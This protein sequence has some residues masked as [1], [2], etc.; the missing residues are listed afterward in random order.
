MFNMPSRSAQNVEYFVNSDESSFTT[1]SRLPVLLRPCTKPSKA[2]IKS[3]ESHRILKWVVV[4][5]KIQKL[6]LSGDVSPRTS[7]NSNSLGVTLPYLFKVLH[8]I[9]RTT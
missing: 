5:H 1:S 8:L 2:A 6:K 3:E 7:T 4:V 9:V